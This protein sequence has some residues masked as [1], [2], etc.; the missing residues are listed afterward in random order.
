MMNYIGIRGHRGAGKSAI[1]WLLG[2]TISYLTKKTGEEISQTT[3]NEW[4]NDVIRDPNIMDKVGMD[5][6]FIESFSDQIK[7]LIQLFLN[8]PHEYLYNDIY[9]DTVVVNMRDFS[10]HEVEAGE[11]FDTVTAKEMYDS[12]NKQEDPQP[13][14]KNTYMYLREFILYFGMEVMQR[15][16]GSN[17]WVKSVSNNTK[18]HDEFFDHGKCY[19]IYMDV[20]TPAEV[21][22]VKKHNGVIIN[23]IRPKNK[24]G[25]SGLERLGRD[26]RID[27]SVNV[28]GSLYE[29]KNQIEAIASD[30]INKFENNGREEAEKD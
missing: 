16:F 28:N 20:K 14:I 5:R 9:K 15:F 8:C 19:K 2:N 11:I 27:Y 30:I 6:V 12:I 13:I 25:A 24:R 26:D 23:V 4:C 3:W 22:H 21:T 1:A 7:V 29:L 17:A 18:M 10:C